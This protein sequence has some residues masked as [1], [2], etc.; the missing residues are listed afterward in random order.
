MSSELIKIGSSGVRVNQ[1]NLQVTGHNIA[2]VDTAGYTR[3]QALQETNDAIAWGN[4]HYGQGA[5]TTTIRR[6]VDEFMVTQ[7]R[8]D[9]SIA[10]E[11]EMVLE[12]SQQLNNLLADADSSPGNALNE[13]FSAMQALADDPNNTTLRNQVLAQSDSLSQRFN[14]MQE[15]FDDM[16]ESINVQLDSSVG[17]INRIATNI[18]LL[19]EGVVKAEAKNGLP[20]NDLRDQREEQ[21]RALSEYVDVSVTK[22]NDGTYSVL[23]GEGFPLVVGRDTYEL[24]AEPLSSDIQ[25]LGIVYPDRDG[26]KDVTG[27]IRGGELGGVLKFRDDILTPAQNQLGRLALTIGET[28]NEQH[29]KGIDLNNE[30][31][32]NFFRDV[33]ELDIMEGRVSAFQGNS[34]SSNIRFSV[35]ITDTTALSDKDYVLKAVDGDTFQIYDTDGNQLRFEKNTSPVTYSNSISLDDL[36]R[37]DG[38]NEDLTLTVDGFQIYLS[39]DAA[40]NVSQGDQFLIQPSRYASGQI[41]REITDADEI[42]IALPLRTE[43]GIANSGTGEVRSV[44]VDNTYKTGIADTKPLPVASSPNPDGVNQPDPSD[45]TGSTLIPTETGSY[46]FV[47]SRDGSFKVYLDEATTSVTGGLA[48]DIAAATTGQANS[49]AVSDSIIAA[50]EAA[51]DAAEAA[52]ETAAGLPAGTLD[53]QGWD[54]M[55]EMDKAVLGAA[56]TAADALADN[57]QDIIDYAAG[58]AGAAAT[59]AAVTGA[60]V[61]SVAEAVKE[62]LEDQGA[63]SQVVNDAV[64]GVKSAANVADAANFASYDIA[65]AYTRDALKGASVDNGVIATTVAAVVAAKGT[66]VAIDPAGMASFAKLAGD[67]AATAK[68]TDITSNTGVA[69]VGAAATDTGVY[70]LKNGVNITFTSESATIPGQLNYEV[71]DP[72][73]DAIIFQGAFTQGQE[74]SLLPSTWGIQVNIAGNPA[75]GDSFTTTYNTDG[76]GD[77]SN[78]LRL[79]ALQGEPTLEGDMSYQDAYAHTTT[80]VGSQTA[81]AKITAQSGAAILEQTSNL[82]NSVSGVNMDEEAANLVRF[83]QA[84]NA[85]SQIISTARQLFDTLLAAVR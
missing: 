7:L 23:I 68:E 28:F 11:R 24:S 49:R 84:Y 51:A 18:A 21:L 57:E 44:A 22:V 38:N 32:H 6:I 17:E 12:Y 55:S 70:D 79:T 4:G 48:A 34:S 41:A 72:D 1:L 27:L 85:S 31:G 58:G 54:L 67:N 56:Y 81:E 78:A 45:P 40:K 66:A 33:N 52:A 53:G 26:D 36:N 46:A 37:Y 43:S 5:N 61:D 9:T 71:R 47:D 83:Q 42:A 80:S 76:A 69:A 75:V 64:N 74:Q 39:T 16:Q 65:A 19:N 50:A 13:F 8:N 59:A 15:R 25:R 63:S 60:T 10:K 30:T 29:Q 35:E 82:R 3:Q 77:N 20:A 62:Y 2:N 14:L 73:T